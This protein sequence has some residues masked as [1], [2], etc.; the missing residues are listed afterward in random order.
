MA[1]PVKSC[2]LSFIEKLYFMS[3]YIDIVDDSED[4]YVADLVAKSALK[5]DE[6]WDAHNVANTIPFVDTGDD[7][8]NLIH[9]FD[10]GTIASRKVSSSSK[11]KATKF[12]GF[13]D[14]GYYYGEDDDEMLS[15]S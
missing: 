8:D 13:G 10:H 3:I 6:Y 15:Y 1:S 5:E 14:T 12:A 7:L 2:T 11:L 4:R 9:G